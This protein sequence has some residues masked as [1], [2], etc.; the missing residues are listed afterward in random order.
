[1]D[2]RMGGARGRE[3]KGDDEILTGRCGG[4]VADEVYDV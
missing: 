4:K 2:V 3:K 1:V